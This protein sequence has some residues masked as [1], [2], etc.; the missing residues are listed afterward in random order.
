VELSFLEPPVTLEQRVL[1]R[2]RRHAEPPSVAPQLPEVLEPVAGGEAAPCRLPAY[3]AE[4]EQELP[5]A[6]VE[7]AVAPRVD[8]RQ[9]RRRRRHAHPAE[10]REQ[11]EPP[12]LAP[13]GAA[14]A[15]GPVALAGASSAAR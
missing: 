2:A 1:D 8:Q 13:R 7:D 4:P 5:S 6:D 15:R 12:P 9:D 14:G 3:G 10:A 11:L